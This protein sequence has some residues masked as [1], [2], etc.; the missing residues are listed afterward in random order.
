MSKVILIG[1]DGFRPDM[2]DAARTPN[3]HTLAS[4][5]VQFSRHTAVFPSETY[6]CTT[7]IMTGQPPARHGIMANSF[8]DPKVSMH[9]PWD[10][11]R[12][13]MIEAGMCAY[14]GRLIAAPTLGDALA[15]AGKRLWVLSGNS[16]GSAR[17]MHPRIADYPRHVLISGHD[18]EHS[19]PGHIANECLGAL[20]RPVSADWP[21]DDMAVQRYITDAFLLLAGQNPLPD[22]TVIWYGEPDHSFHAFGLS[23]PQTRTTLRSLDVE[24]GRIV[25]WWQ[26]HPER[27]QIQLIVTSDHGHLTQTHRVDTRSIFESCGLRVGQN[28]AEGA[29]IALAPGYVG[30]LRVRN[31]DP[32]LAAAA[33]AALMAHPQAGLVLTAAGTDI[34]GIVKGTFSQSLVGLNHPGRSPDITFTLR[35]CAPSVPSNKCTCCFDNSLSVGAGTHGGL[36]PDEMACLLVMAGGAFAQSRKIQAPSS[37]I[38]ILPTILCLLQEDANSLPGRV[39]SEAFSNHLPAREAMQVQVFRIGSGEYEQEIHFLKWGKYRYLNRGRRI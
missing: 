17:L 27:E 20:G 7:S 6:V 29:D 14:D 2:L 21:S 23:A 38:D 4:L 26:S 13:D 30:N 34:E 1:L 33:A 5:G 18:L 22:A 31:G 3:L 8:F 9:E 32:G 25:D 36:H 10:G 39:L 16:P 37:L 12:L 11:S 15:H 19:L 28:V 35:T 24:V